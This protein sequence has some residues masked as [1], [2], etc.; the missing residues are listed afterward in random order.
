MPRPSPPRNIDRIAALGG[1]IA[2]QHRMAFQGEYFAERYGVE[3]TAAT[4]PIQAMLA[5][6]LPVGGG[7][8]ATRV[9]SYNPWVSLWWL[10]SGRTVGGLEMYPP[11]NRLDRE[12]ALRLWTEGSAWFS[13]EA[14]R[15][16]RIAQGQLADLVVLSEDY[17]TVDEPRIRHIESLLTMVGGKVVHGAD[18]YQGM[19]PP[20]PPAAPDWSPVGYYGGYQRADANPATVHAHAMAAACA[21]GQSCGVH[22]H[23]HGH[24]AAAPVREDELAGFWGVSG[25]LLLG[26]LRARHARASL[27]RTIVA[28]TFALRLMSVEA[29]AQTA[30]RPGFKPLRQD[31]DWSVLCDPALRAGLIDRLK[32][33]PLAAD[34]SAWLSLGGEIRERYEYTHNPVWGDDPQDDNGVFLQR[35][36]LQGD[37]RVGPNL[38]LFGQLYSALA[39]GRAG[40]TSPVDENQL[41]VQQ[42]FVELSAP[43]PEDSSGMLRAGRQELRYGSGRLVDVREGPNVRRK[44]DGGLGRLAKDKWRLDLIATRPADD[45]PGFF[46]DGTNGSQALWGSYV[47]GRSPG[48][49][50]F[51]SS[52]PVQTVL[53]LPVHARDLGEAGGAER[54]AAGSSGWRWW[55]GRRSHGWR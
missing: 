33:V 1:G 53:D 27:V 15:K 9:A 21:C 54:A 41:D 13:S 12:T 23:A 31:E 18:G 43:L 26:G 28:A 11:A 49:L 36:M 16:G 51:G 50:P 29:M 3:A 19:A 25:L 17:M 10:V 42:A 2:I 14:G 20:L 38:R 6:G 22:G 7:T 8:D 35:Y 45:E 24:I 52:N 4:P 40:P 34:G 47:T 5:A 46:D 37:L 48:W 44:F 30:A 32:C 55:L 39:A